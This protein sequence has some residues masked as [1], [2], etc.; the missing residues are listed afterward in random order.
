[1]VTEATEYT[2]NVMHS[3]LFLKF[4][5]ELEGLRVG[6]NLKFFNY[7]VNDYEAKLVLK[8]LSTNQRWKFM[9][10]PI[11]GDV[12]VLCKKIPLTKY[13]NLQENLLNENVS[14]SNTLKNLNRD[15]SKVWQ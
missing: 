13:L 2:I 9:Y 1:M 10:R 6:I 4:H 15:V 12:Q 5:K 14:L 11:H 8:L 7:E 3:E